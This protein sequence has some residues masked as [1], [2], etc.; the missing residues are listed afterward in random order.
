MVHW[1]RTKIVAT[2]GPATSSPDVLEQMIR[3]GVN[4]FRINF[5]HG[6]HDVISQAVHHIRELNRKLNTNVG[7]LADLQGPKLRIGEVEKGT[8]LEPGKEILITTRECVGNPGKVYITYPQFP[9]DVEVGNL[10]LIDDGKILLRAVSTNEKDEV[11]A[12]VVHGG[13][14]S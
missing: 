7:L 4:I 12:V 8:E 14:I 1:N 11:K 10:I 9:K 6:A 5:S 13:L 2:L 3:A